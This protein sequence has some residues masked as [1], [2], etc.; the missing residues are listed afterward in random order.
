MSHGVPQDQARS[1][2]Q[3]LE[4]AVGE[5]ALQQAMLSTD[6]KVRWVCFE[7]CFQPCTVPLAQSG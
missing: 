7:A 4:K 3:A 2:A 5:T 6:D 1:R